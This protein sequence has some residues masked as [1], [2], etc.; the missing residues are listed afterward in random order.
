MAAGLWPAAC[1][2]FNCSDNNITFLGRG[3]FKGP[4]V[5]RE[6]DLSG[7]IIGPISADVFDLADGLVAPAMEAA[8]SV[9]VLLPHLAPA[10]LG[11][12]G[13]GTFCVDQDLYSF[14]LAS[15]PANSTIKCTFDDPLKISRSAECRTSGTISSWSCRK[16]YGFLIA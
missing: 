9:C 13:N 12:A 8:G 6:V 1:W 16:E 4:G 11:F 3:A 10:R 15:L 5:L 14:C 7:N 2:K